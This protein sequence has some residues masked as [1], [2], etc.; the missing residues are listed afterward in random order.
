MG[1]CEMGGRGIASRQLRRRAAV[2]STM[3]QAAVRLDGFLG[4][5]RNGYGEEEKKKQ[6]KKKKKRENEEGKGVWSCGS[7]SWGWEERVG[8]ETGKKDKKKLKKKMR[9]RKR[10]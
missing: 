1:K 7:L 4:E 9:W 3:L 6:K 10:K 8:E 2:A 5:G